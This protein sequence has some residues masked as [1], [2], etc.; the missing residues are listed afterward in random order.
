MAGDT[1]SLKEFVERIFD[2]H[3][4]ALDL[5]AAALREKLQE[6]N[7]FRLQLERER[8]LYIQGKDLTAILDRLRKL[9]DRDSNRDGKIWALG[10]F[11]A[12]MTTLVNL[13]LRFWI[14]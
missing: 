1:V 8:A 11:L 14:K 6:M 7:Q 12:I 13:A 3:G 5:T 9:E 4:R 10:V 2:E